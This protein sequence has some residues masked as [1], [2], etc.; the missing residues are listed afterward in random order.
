VPLLVAPLGLVA[1]ANVWYLVGAR[2]DRLRVLR[3]SRVQK[4]SLRPETFE[5]P[6]GFDLPTFW[7]NWCDELESSRPEY[8]VRARVSPILAQ[9]LAEGRPET[10]HTAP[11]QDEHGWQQVNLN[12]ENLEAARMRILGYGGAIEVLEPL[13]LRL[14]VMDFAAQIRARYPQKTS[15]G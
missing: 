8:R 15:S 9:I 6:A 10:L 3:I 1:K 7:K 11:V 12:F 13:A 5:R 4:A 2:D 14:S